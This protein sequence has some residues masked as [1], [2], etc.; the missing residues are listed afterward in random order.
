M[1]TYLRSSTKTYF[2]NQPSGP[3]VGLALALGELATRGRSDY[4]CNAT[5]SIC[6]GGRSRV[7]AHAP[8]DGHGNRRAACC[9]FCQSFTNARSCAT[10]IGSLRDRVI[11]ATVELCVTA[12]KIS[13][14]S[15]NLILASDI[16]I[17]KV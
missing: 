4:L 13:V 6:V 15:S 17:S 5:R 2:M 16:G 3:K 7:L 10:P 9:Q 11:V 12:N 8:R 1:K 14:N